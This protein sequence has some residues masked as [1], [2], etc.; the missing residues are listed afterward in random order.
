MPAVGVTRVDDENDERLADYRNVPD[1]DLLVGRRLFVAEGRLVVR[2]LLTPGGLAARSVLVTEAALA[3][4]EDAIAGRPEVAVY[5]VPQ[6]VMDGIAGFNV[7]RGCLAL[8]ERPPR[9]DWREI[10]RVA[11]RLAILE[12]VGN[13]DNVGAV[14][15]NAAAFGF[16]GVLIG[17]SCADPLYRKAIRTSMGAVLTLP[18]APAEPWPGTL[19]LLRDDGWMVV[20]M[21]PAPGAPS[22]GD[23]FATAAATRVAV[24]IGHEGD[25]LTRHALDACEHHARIPIAAPV[26]SLN[27]ATAAAIAFYELGRRDEPGTRGPGQN[28]GSMIR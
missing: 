4:L 1:P 17:P 21:V 12:R 14:F 28:P 5:V 18:S 22:L 16:G 2:R 19:R 27:A 3:S 11:R 23:V 6:R 26:D 15:R 7:H 8:G 24:V 13:P 10:V 20:A 9:G 25:G